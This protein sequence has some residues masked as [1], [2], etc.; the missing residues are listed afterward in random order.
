MSGVFTNQSILYIVARSLKDD[1][2]LALSAHLA[3]QSFW[4]QAGYYAHPD[5]IWI[6]GNP[7]YD[8]RA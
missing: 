4:R 2:E 5:L 8:P 7:H 1:P 3:I 6:L